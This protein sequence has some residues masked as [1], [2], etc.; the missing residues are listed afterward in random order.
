MAGPYFGSF[1]ARGPEPTSFGPR[2]T[3]CPE[4]EY[5]R[6]PRDH[7]RPIASVPPTRPHP[8][9][10][11]TLHPP[12]SHKNVCIAE[13]HSPRDQTALR[14]PP[15]HAATGHRFGAT[16]HAQRPTH[17]HPTL[18]PGGRST[19]YSR[20]TRGRRREVSRRRRRCSRARGAQWRPR[21][22]GGTIR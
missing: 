13:F 4:T 10:D 1:G 15:A 18:R 17:R 21:P 2:D 19:P 12:C 7:R 3:L 9:P 20:P 16:A 8:E 6:I 11:R 14:F 22:A 5:L